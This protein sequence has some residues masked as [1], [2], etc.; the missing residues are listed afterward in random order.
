FDEGYVAN[1]LLNQH[2]ICL[3]IYGAHRTSSIKGHTMTLPWVFTAARRTLQILLIAT[4]LLL[5][6]QSAS[7]QQA[8]ISGTV[9]DPS[10][11]V[12]SG[13]SVELVQVATK[14]RWDLRTNDQ[15][16]YVASSLPSGEFR[17]IARAKDFETRVLEGVRVEVA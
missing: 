6:Q 2:Y 15:G 8:Q 11:A 17:I 4:G 12:I 14:D 7:A 5:L 9:R 3:W 16:R 1:F 13:A 10:D